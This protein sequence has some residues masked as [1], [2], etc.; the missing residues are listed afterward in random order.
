M[1]ALK[2]ASCGGWTNKEREG[3]ACA[4]QP[5]AAGLRRGIW[6]GEGLHLPH[7][8]QQRERVVDVREVQ[9]LEEGGSGETSRADGH[10]ASGARVVVGDLH[11]GE[12]AVPAGPRA[13]VLVPRVDG[14]LH[15]GFASLRV[16]TPANED[17]G[18]LNGRMTIA[19]LW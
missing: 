9:P 11:G 14:E 10:S 12:V 5:D 7:R 6:L 8:P 18:E 3:H 15:V 17:G 4:L 13:A 19:H 1:M 2:G 16:R